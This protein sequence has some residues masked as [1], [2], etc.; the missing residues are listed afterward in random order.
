MYRAFKKKKNHLNKNSYFDNY[1]RFLPVFGETIRYLR[2]KVAHFKKNVMG[3]VNAKCSCGWKSKEE[4]FRKD[5]RGTLKTKLY[6]LKILD[7]NMHNTV[8]K[9]CC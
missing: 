6:L 1:S 2:K 5:D 9:R 8:S 7:K 3:N 4:K